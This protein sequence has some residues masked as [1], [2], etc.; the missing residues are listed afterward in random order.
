[1]GHN[2]GHYFTASDRSLLFSFV[3][4]GLR[5][6]LTSIPNSYLY[7]FVF[8][9]ETVAGRVGSIDAA[10]DARPEPDLSGKQSCLVSCLLPSSQIVTLNGLLFGN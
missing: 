1:M 9:I 5:S 3:L 6:L 8:Q 10:E 2:R 4:C 7:A